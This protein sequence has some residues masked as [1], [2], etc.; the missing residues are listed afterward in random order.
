MPPAINR[1]LLSDKAR[2]SDN[3]GHDEASAREA[4]NPMCDGYKRSVSCG[5][6]LFAVSKAV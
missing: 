6:R 5:G 1:G 4:E 3:T 2:Y